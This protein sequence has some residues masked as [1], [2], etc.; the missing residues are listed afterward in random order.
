MFSNFDPSDRPVTE[1]NKTEN[2]IRRNEQVMADFFANAPM[3][4]MW[5][6]PDG[7]VLRA[8]RA[9]GILLGLPDG[10]SPGRPVTGILTDPRPV[11][12]LLEQLASGASITNF[13][14]AATPKG[15]NLR[16][17]L[18]DAN[19]LWSE[20][21][22][23]H[24][25]WFIRDITD[26]VTLETEI[27]AIAERERERIG[28]DLHDDLCQ[29]LIGLDFQLETLI[30][31]WAAV[32][33][34]GEIRG[35]QISA[36][37]R[38]VAAH[39]RGLAH[40]LYPNG[41][42]APDG[43]MNALAELAS[44]TERVFK[45]RCRFI[46]E[47]PFLVPNESAGIQLYRIAQEAVGNALKHAKATEIEIRLAARDGFVMLAVKDNGIGIATPTPSGKGVGLRIM[48]YRSG[49]IGGSLTVQ[50]NPNGGTEIV[51]T[52]RDTCSSP[53]A[54]KPSP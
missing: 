35:R 43:L 44:A 52:I 12:A 10:E 13:H 36:G 27:L 34:Q 6:L 17:L 41:H 40:G 19:G 23:E 7:C 38:K 39:A 21:R 9:A 30:D 26:R 47:N 20:D 1:R 15:G 25:R 49:I 32:A 54:S 18:I 16:H 53:T 3:G 8:N 50:R 45:R 2:L 37:I 33:P 11:V 48:Q 31:E 28:H 51:C 14:L 4:I 42:F 22:L 5:V 46:G 24:T 29:Q